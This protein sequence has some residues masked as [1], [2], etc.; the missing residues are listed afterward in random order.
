MESYLPVSVYQDGFMDNM[1]RSGGRHSFTPAPRYEE[2]PRY[3]LEFL[4]ASRLNDIHPKTLGSRGY[5]EPSP[6]RK[7]LYQRPVKRRPA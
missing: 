7:N 4:A 2:K 3:F 5:A 1:S 6:V